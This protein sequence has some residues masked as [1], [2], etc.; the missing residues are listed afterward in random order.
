[1]AWAQRLLKILPGFGSPIQNDL[2]FQ[3]VGTALSTTSVQTTSL[4]GLTPTISAGY[5]RVKIYGAT[6]TSPT[7]LKLLVIL[8]DG[9]NFVN[10][11]QLIPVVASA[12]VLSIVP[13]GTV[14]G[15]GD[16]A[17]TSGLKVLT[18]V[19]APFLPTMVG[20]AISVS[21]AGTGATI[22]YTTIATYNSPSSVTLATAAGATATAGVMTLT[23]DYGNGGSNTNPG[24]FD[25]VTPFLVDINVSQCSVQTTLGGT[26]PTALLD[27]E[28][29][30][31][32]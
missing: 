29:S 3:S 8:S 5:V 7:L 4:A 17:I 32:T 19:S 22:L 2:L 23:S 26:S 27:V 24:G 16:G 6:G 13:G 15:A 21:T 30:G 28:I 31:T 18:A 11:A 10:V 25:F 1:M 14:I 12:P 9:T 20:D